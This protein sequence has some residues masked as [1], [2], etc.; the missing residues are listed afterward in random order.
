VGH[1]Y[2]YFIDKEGD[3]RRQ[4]QLYGYRKAEASQKGM[5]V[6]PFSTSLDILEQVLSAPYLLD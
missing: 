3:S 4:E 2:V 6:S 5:S 1:F